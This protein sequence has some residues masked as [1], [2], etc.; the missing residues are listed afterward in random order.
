MYGGEGLCYIYCD[1]ARLVPNTL[2]S[3]ASCGT[4]SLS[5][6]YPPTSQRVG[7]LPSCPLFCSFFSSI[8]FQALCR[9]FQLWCL[10][11]CINDILSIRQPRSTPLLLPTPPAPTVLSLPLP[12]CSRDLEKCPRMYRLL[13]S[14]LKLDKIPLL[15]YNPLPKQVVRSSLRTLE[16][17]FSLLF[18][19]SLQRSEHIRLLPHSP[20]CLSPTSV[21]LEAC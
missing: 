15:E 1:N 2:G 8:L 19:A 11:D 9:Q 13:I 17:C 10:H 18:A 4:F 20:F 12:Q 7:L 3:H 6:T 5:D 16:G 14:S 21:P